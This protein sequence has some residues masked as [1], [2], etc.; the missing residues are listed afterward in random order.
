LVRFL[1]SGSGGDLLYRPA[2]RRAYLG[3]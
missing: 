2:V 3:G 1:V